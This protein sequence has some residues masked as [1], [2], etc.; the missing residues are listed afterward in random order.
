ML[1]LNTDLLVEIVDNFL[2]PFNCDSDFDSDFFYSSREQRI[3]FTLAYSER[4][5]KL[6]KQYVFSEFHYEISNIFLLS[7]LHELGHHFTLSNFSD[8]EIRKEHKRKR[9]IEAELTKTDSNEA[10][11]KYF[12]LPIEKTATE[13]AINY[14]KENKKSCDDF[15]SIFEEAVKKEYERLE[16][17]D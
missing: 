14:Y 11:L 9:K 6:F 16:L 17:A 3:Y 12:D 10:F 1:N 13:W 2:E 5:D 7:L 8:I 15:Y 4:A